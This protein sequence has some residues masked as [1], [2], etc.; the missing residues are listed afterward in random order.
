MCV[1]VCVFVV[2]VLCVHACMLPREERVCV[3]ASE[4]AIFRN[5][6]FGKQGCN[7]DALVEGEA[8]LKTTSL[9]RAAGQTAMGSPGG[10]RGHE[11]RRRAAASGARVAQNRRQVKKRATKNDPAAPRATS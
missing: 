3:G 1:C 10:E 8:P 2:C 11:R 7:G 6:G 4:R 5:P 9:P